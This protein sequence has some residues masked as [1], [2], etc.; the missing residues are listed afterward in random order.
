MLVG[1]SMLFTLEGALVWNIYA[2]WLPE[3]NHAPS[4]SCEKHLQFAVHSFLSMVLTGGVLTYLFTDVD[5][6]NTVL[7]RNFGYNDITAVFDYPPSVYV[8]PAYWFVTA[9]GFL[10]YALEDTRRLL[11]Q[12]PMRL[13]TSS[14]YAVNAAMAAAA[15]LFSVALAV[16]AEEDFAMHTFPIL[17]LVL[18]M[19]LPFVMQAL[20]VFSKRAE[21]K[22]PDRSYGLLLIFVS[23]FAGVSLMKGG[24][25]LFALFAQPVSESFAKPLDGLWL[26]LVFVLPFLLHPAPGG[27]YQ[28]LPPELTSPRSTTPPGTPSP[29]CLVV[30]CLGLVLLAVTGVVYGTLVNHTIRP[31]RTGGWS[32]GSAV[33]YNTLMHSR[34][35]ANQGEDCSCPGGF[36]IFG[37]GTD[38]EHFSDRVFWAKWDV[39]P[40]RILEMLPCRTEILGDPIVFSDSEECRCVQ[41]GLVCKQLSQPTASG[42]R[43][44]APD[45]EFERMGLSDRERECCNQHD[46]CY[47]LC[48]HSKQ[49]CDEDYGECLEATCGTGLDQGDISFCRTRVKH[50]RQA[51]GLE[52]GQVAYS[53]AQRSREHWFLSRGHNSTLDT[54]HIL[55]PTAHGGFNCHSGEK[56]WQVEW[57]PEKKSWCCA[58][59]KVGCMK[60]KP[61]KPSGKAKGA[62]ARSEAVSTTPSTSSTSS[63]S[64][65]NSSGDG[66]SS[67]RREPQPK[68]TV[69]SSTTFQAAQTTVRPTTTVQGRLP[70][71]IS[72]SKSAPAT[73]TVP[74]VTTAMPDNLP[75]RS[76]HTTNQAP[77]VSPQ[78]TQLAA[79]AALSPRR[80]FNCLTKDRWS[81]NKT[82]WCCTNLGLGCQDGTN[83]PDES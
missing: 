32:D 12:A 27:V 23:W 60:L 66:T 58:R 1:Y 59:E 76:S 75:W 13:L 29:K 74:L 9:F 42:C 25:T 39:Y 36:V 45:D 47:G 21:L 34:H 70:P 24:M 48:D 54:N 43:S 80:P 61:P 7:A 19:P 56:Y 33:G 26:F 22:R 53:S 57:S 30:A 62:Q 28:Q 65:S 15:L 35:C 63:S 44:S 64:S 40:N 6:D 11:R 31:L 37:R 51:A 78:Q 41:A 52:I 71:R 55:G 79:A 49:K 8:M 20:E 14:A 4:P 77:P 72:A 46:R 69:L 2:E 5:W 73:T 83:Q 3:P 82:V 50:L 18:V 17:C 81:A 16:R 38:R 68:P 10:L 67:S